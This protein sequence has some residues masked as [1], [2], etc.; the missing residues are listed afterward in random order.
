MEQVVLNLLL[1]VLVIKELKQLVMRLLETMCLAQ[2][3]P[4]PLQLMPV[5][6]EHVL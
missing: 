6:I 1:L 3:H 4:L 5:K 2:T